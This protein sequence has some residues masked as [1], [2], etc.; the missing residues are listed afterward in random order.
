MKNN[1]SV[2]SIEN[3]CTVY[4]KQRRE[5][6]TQ[7]VHK[8]M[9]SISDHK[10]RYHLKCRKNQTKCASVD[11]LCAHHRIKFLLN[12]FLFLV[13]QPFGKHIK[14]LYAIQHL[15]LLVFILLIYLNDWVFCWRNNSSIRTINSL[16]LRV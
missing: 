8:H 15:A 10:Q 3:I 7:R 5:I 13:S 9:D 6:L 2:W 16:I 14:I 11:E 12:W 1:D 4:I